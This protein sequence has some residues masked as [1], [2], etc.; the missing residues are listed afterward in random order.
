MLHQKLSNTKNNVINAMINAMLNTNPFVRCLRAAVRFFSLASGLKAMDNRTVTTI[1]AIM[2]K[3][4]RF[5]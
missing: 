2:H 4:I 5:G 1:H 3:S